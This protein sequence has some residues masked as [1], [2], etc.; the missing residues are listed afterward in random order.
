MYL[1]YTYYTKQHSGN[2][3]VLLDISD[4]TYLPRLVASTLDCS[5]A[6]KMHR[7]SN[8]KGCRAIESIDIYFL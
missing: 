5:I 3:N 6:I 8:S 2:I 4:P 7:L 1:I